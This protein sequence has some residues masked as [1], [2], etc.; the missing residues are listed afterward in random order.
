MTEE[1]VLAVQCAYCDRAISILYERD[2]TR[3]VRATAYFCP[4][5]DCHTP[6]FQW[7]EFSGLLLDVSTG[8]RRRTES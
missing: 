8:H 7:V 5:I 1:V 2:A 4:Y 3:P 6:R